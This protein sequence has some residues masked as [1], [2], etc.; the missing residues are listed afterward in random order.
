M[1]K[2]C[3]A[4]GSE[5]ELS[6]SGKRQKYCPNCSQRGIGHICGLPA[7]NPLKLKAAESRFKEESVSE[8]IERKKLI[9]AR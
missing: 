7:S 8:Q 6:G 9:R 3:L 2:R 1:K 4:C 5:F